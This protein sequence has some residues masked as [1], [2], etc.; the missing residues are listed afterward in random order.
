MQSGW[1]LDWLDSHADY[2]PAIFLDAE[3]SN[4]DITASTD[5][6]DAMRT[7]VNLDDDVH[8]LACAVAE[9]RSISLGKAISDL[10]RKGARAEMPTRKVRG[11]VVFDLPPDS[12]VVTMETVKR[13]ESE[14]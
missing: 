4:V 2:G 5:E 6:N 12:P 7:T 1:W 13:L 14:L 10:A 11:L 8:K 9:L 3:S